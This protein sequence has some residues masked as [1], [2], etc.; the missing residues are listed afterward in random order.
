V[1]LAV[2]ATQRRAISPLGSISTQI[3]SFGRGEVY[4][5]VLPPTDSQLV[6]VAG[7]SAWLF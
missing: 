7:W 1:V 5:R 6:A 2:E 3:L 4:R